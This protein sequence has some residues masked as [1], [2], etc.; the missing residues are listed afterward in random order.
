MDE[1]QL[2]A[3]KEFEVRFSE[4]DSMGI[5]WH[6][7]YAKYFEDGREEFGR[8]FGLGYMRIF[9]S[10]FYAPLVEL[11]FKYKKPLT[12]E[13]KAVVEVKYINTAAAKIQFEYR[14]FLPEDNSTICTGKST[15][16]FLDKDYQLTWFNPPFYEEWKA[17]HGL[18]FA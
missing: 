9:K 17:E 12:Y 1:N 10:G 7:S 11:D 18:T 4:V 15:Q 8:K 14:I 3:Y 2:V 5:V 6:G 13:T 16:V